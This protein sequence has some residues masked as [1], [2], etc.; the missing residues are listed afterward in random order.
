MAIK[1]SPTGV[2]VSAPVD[3][4]SAGRGGTLALQ[5]VLRVICIQENSAGTGFL[6]KSGKIITAEHVVRGCNSP[7]LMLPNGTTRPASVVATDAET[8][9][10][11]LNPA[12]AIA[13]DALPLS[14][15]SD[16]AVGAQVSTWGFPGGYSG[17]SPMLSVGYIAGIDGLRTPSGKIIRQWVVNA[18]FNAGNS[19]GP[20][21]HIETGEVIGVVSS[22]LAPISPEAAH[23]LNILEQQK[24]GMQY[25]GKNPD[26]SEISFSEAQLVGMVLNELRRQVQLVI[27]KAV[28][29]ED[30]KSFLKAQK[31]DP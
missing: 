1:N 25:S 26:G 3:T 18:A 7:I 22:K 11:L 30:I 24:S 19:G 13:V 8:D 12:S 2:P 29:A 17:L 31:I 14:F 5:S 27:G 4:D 15:R 10:A 28:L 20:L 16:P 6:H 9:L 21:L 23:I